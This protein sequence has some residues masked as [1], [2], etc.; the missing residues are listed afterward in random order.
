MPT[1][2]CV[3]I[4]SEVFTTFSVQTNHILCSLDSKFEV[5]SYQRRSDMVHLKKS[6]RFPLT[7]KAEKKQ[8][9][10]EAAI[11]TRK[12]DKTRLAALVN[13]GLDVIVLVSN[14]DSLFSNLTPQSPYLRLFLLLLL[15]L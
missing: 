11:G 1:Y 7:S 13:A 15:V 14:I 2:N 6:R 5:S 10:V 12:E 4:N 3:V 9:L 8:L